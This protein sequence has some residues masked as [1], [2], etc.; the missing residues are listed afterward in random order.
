MKKLI[1]IIG[2][3][4]S[5][6]TLIDILLGNDKNIFSA[7]EINRFPK[8]NGIPP[9]RA[10][11]NITWRFWIDIKNNLNNVNLHDQE[12]LGRALEYH[13]GFFNRKKCKFLISYYSYLRQFFKLLI[14]KI[15]E[16]VVIDS[17]KY[18]LRAYH[19]SIVVPEFKYC[20]YL[21]RHPVSIVRSFKKMDIEQ[22]SK[23]WFWVN[24][25][26][27]IVHLLTNWTIRRL[28]KNGIKVKE[29]SFEEIVNNPINFIDQLEES[30]DLDLKDLK[31]KLLKEKALHTNH[32]FDGNRIRLK[33]RV[34]IN[35]NIPAVN[36]T[37]GERIVY[38]CN[39][40]WWKNK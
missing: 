14:A 12:K 2:T 1:Y 28:K 19:L 34:Y 9:G 11:C 13:S 18:P 31:L 40:F 35:A 24:L 20:I 27:I 26:L 10:V 3:G 37:L 25:Y 16:S 29:V 22:P 4:R 7:G 30:F 21:K 17:S 6:T 8:R 5:G 38:I 33:S 39:R 23:S 32:L 15:N 36:W